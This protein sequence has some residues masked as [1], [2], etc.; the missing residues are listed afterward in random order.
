MR[1]GLLNRVFPVLLILT[2]MV[3]LVGASAEAGKS[4]EGDYETRSITV[5]LTA[6]GVGFTAVGAIAAIVMPLLNQDAKA[7]A[8]TTLSLP[9]SEEEHDEQTILMFRTLEHLF[10]SHERSLDRQG[11]AIFHNETM[12]AHLDACAEARPTPQLR[13]ARAFLVEHFRAKHIDPVAGAEWARF[14]AEVLE[15]RRPPSP[16]LALKAQ[17]EE[18]TE[19]EDPVLER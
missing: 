15:S 7:A 2:G 1:R 5:V 14:N 8:P 12:L 19:A 9:M 10:A 13:A 4:A 17:T 11:S 18:L 6:I 3:F 16:K